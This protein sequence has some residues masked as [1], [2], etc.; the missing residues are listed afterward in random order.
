MD[1]IDFG[2]FGHV[3]AR[4]HP[5]IALGRGSGADGIG[6]V[7]SPNVWS[8][9][10]Y[11]RIDRDRCN[12][13][14]AQ[15]PGDAHGNFS[16]V[17]DQN[18]FDARGGF[19]GPGHGGYFPLPPSFKWKSGGVLSSTG[20]GVKSGR[21]R[22]AGRLAHGWIVR[23]NWLWARDKLDTGHCVPKMG[24]PMTEPKIG[25]SRV[26]PPSISGGPSVSTETPGAGQPVVAVTK[27]AT[28]ATTPVDVG[29]R[30]SRPGDQA[31]Q[32]AT[33]LANKAAGQTDAD[34]K[35][36]SIA[37]V[38][39][40]ISAPKLS[41]SLPGLASRLDNGSVQ[42]KMHMV[43][44]AK[45]GPLRVRPGTSIVANVTV[46]NGELDYSKTRFVFEKPDHAPT[47]IEG[48]V[49]FFNAD[50]KSIYIDGNGHLHA[51]LPC[52]ANL[53]ATIAGKSDITK[54]VLGPEYDKVPKDPAKLVEAL[55]KRAGMNDNIA[56]Y[57]RPDAPA[58]PPKIAEG[59]GKIIDSKS[60]TVGFHGT[61][62]AGPLKLGDGVVINLD[63]GA[64][65]NCAGAKLS[66]P[67]NIEADIDAPVKSLQVQAEG[68]RLRSG[69]GHVKIHVTL[70][71]QPDG[72]TLTDV[73]FPEFALSDL[74]FETPGNVGKQHLH[75][76]QEVSVASKAGAPAGLSYTSGAGATAPRI[77]ANIPE[78]D[79]RGVTGELELA[80]AGGKPAQF[81]LGD[82]GTGA[83]PKPI[84]VTAHIE[85]DSATNK[86]VL[87]G[88][89]DDMS[90]TLSPIELVRMEGLDLKLNQHK[91]SGAGTISYTSENGKSHFELQAADH[92]PWTMEGSLAKDTYLGGGDAT[93]SIQIGI[94][95]GTHGRMS[96]HS[97]AFDTG[98]PPVFAS[99]IVKGSAAEFEVKVKRVDL[100]LPGGHQFHIS[101]G[102]TGTLIFKDLNWQK[103]ARAP[104]VNATLSL[105]LGANAVMLP[106][107]I[108][109]LEGARVT[110]DAATGQTTLELDAK[111]DRNGRVTCTGGITIRNFDVRTQLKKGDIKAVPD[112][113]VP[114]EPLKPT[115]PTKLKTLRTL[116]PPPKSGT[117]VPSIDPASLQPPRIL[118]SPTQILGALDSVDPTQNGIPGFTVTI[119]VG[120]LD[121]KLVDSKA[122]TVQIKRPAAPVQIRLDVRDGKLQ[123]NSSAFVVDPFLELTVHTPV[124]SSTVTVRRFILRVGKD[125]KGYL[126]PD[127]A[128][129]GALLRL[130][131]TGVLAEAIVTMGFGAASVTPKHQEQFLKQVIANEF[132]NA[133]FGPEGSPR[134]G[135]VG[136]VKNALYVRKIPLDVGGLT[137]VLA[138]RY[139]AV[140]GDHVIDPNGPCATTPKK[141]ADPK[142]PLEKIDWGKTDYEVRGARLRPTKLDLGQGQTIELAPGSDLHVSGTAADITVSGHARLGEVRLGNAK[143]GASMSNA[144]GDFTLHIVTNPDCKK[145]FTVDVKNLQADKLAA[146]LGSTKGAVSLKGGKIAKG[147]SLHYQ[148]TSGQP[149]ELSL[150]LPHVDGEIDGGGNSHATVSGSLKLNNGKLVGKLDAL[151]L[152]ATDMTIPADGGGVHKGNVHITGSAQLTADDTGKF[153]VAR[154][155][156]P[157]PGNGFVADVDFTLND[158]S[159]INVTGGRAD[160]ITLE[161]GHPPSIEATNL[162]AQFSCVIPLDRSKKG[163]NPTLIDLRTA[164]ISGSLRVG[165][166]GIETIGKLRVNNA[167]GSLANLSVAPTAQNRI[168]VNQLDV[169][170][171]ASLQRLPDGSWEMTDAS[172]TDAKGKQHRGLFAEGLT[173]DIQF[174]TTGPEMH[175]DVGEGAHATFDVLRL[176]VGGHVEPSV[177][178]ANGK[179]T[180]TVKTGS[181]RVGAPTDVVDRLNFKAGTLVEGKVGSLVS[182]IYLPK[183]AGSVSINSS[184][185]LEGDFYDEAKSFDRTGFELEDLG[186]AGNAR[187][188][189]NLATDGAGNFSVYSDSKVN[190]DVKIKA[191]GDVD[192]RQA[193]EKGV[194]KATK[195]AAD[196]AAKLP[197]APKA[198]AKPGP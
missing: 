150:D 113:T 167:D 183:K 8:D 18:S 14:F 194:T 86:T 181:I 152:V 57:P 121:T 49:L 50:A 144:E 134:T 44:N 171:N 45:V 126:E 166:K 164:D 122:L 154:L 189:M 131:E 3:D 61:L 135:I 70:R 141:A 149:A 76:K 175:V 111:V 47:S 192:G 19:L 168:D 115:G 179:F 182:G 110:V 184:L 123:P 118:E 99:E 128:I 176:R 21:F 74:D 155:D 40:H 9:A 37:S 174:A 148:A 124:A 11:V 22:L 42:V 89:V 4:I 195:A 161:N 92:H 73:S 197:T 105:T 93:S 125:G 64:K 103:G 31:I 51:E 96:L 95:S 193:W 94:E 32:K 151:D 146:T 6:H 27:G 160:S 67:D 156:S 127:I 71:K 29:V 196:V 119:P 102:S 117:P 163:K 91:L 165:K 81:K 66:D 54:L 158:G 106:G 140:F 142:N 185:R 62:E 68:T 107:E 139:P 172:Y 132:S 137:G 55:T 7:C 88:R 191:S 53:L 20:S 17:R 83:A 133:V 180:G 52:I 84:N 38:P 15:R 46:T 100:N 79:L 1:R 48:K 120:E 85:V 80:D 114:A 143:L 28:V 12:P 87:S 26:S 153:V 130:I 41:A 43:D 112:V 60:T 59:F 33:V 39:G 75:I 25:T 162:R 82:G 65:I 30:Q 34:R 104:S 173:H 35:A 188:A 16:P 116:A 129:S 109:G 108:P 170:G 198:P 177:E 13:H 5:Q 136:G 138:R 72:S 63:E 77:Q 169:R 187:L 69:P 190:A 147:A 58:I 101:E 145:I 10:I 78:L 186:I 178:L 23:N 56:I 24:G 36:A 159:R 98:E 2:F 97:L 90:A 157:G